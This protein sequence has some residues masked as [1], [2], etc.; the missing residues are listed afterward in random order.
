MIFKV[1]IIVKASPKVFG[2]ILT[3]GM[4]VFR[5]T[6]IGIMKRFIVL[7]ANETALL[8]LNKED[9]CGSNKNL[10]LAITTCLQGSPLSVNQAGTIALA[11]ECGR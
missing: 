3:L 7:A 11:G 5:K 6:S 4:I 8:Y 9:P 2:E 10:L 1:I